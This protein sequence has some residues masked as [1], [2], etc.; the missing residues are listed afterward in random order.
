MCLYDDYIGNQNYQYYN[1]MHVNPME[2][3]DTSKS[4]YQFIQEYFQAG[5]KLHVFTLN[6]NK[7]VQRAGKHQHTVALYFLGCKLYQLIDSPLKQFFVENLKDSRWYDFKYTWFLACLYHDTASAIEKTAYSNE[8]LDFFLGTNNIK[9]N[10]FNHKP[11]LPYAD[12]F[13]FPEELV[14]NYFHYRIDYCKS[15]DHGILGGFLLF[16]RLR[17]NYDN[18]WRKCCLQNANKRIVDDQF[19][20]T[21]EK[22]EFEDRNWQIDHLDHFAIIADSVIAHNIWFNNNVELYKH[23]GLEPLIISNK[24]QIALTDRPLLFFLSLLDTIEPIKCLGRKNFSLNPVDA[25]KSVSIKLDGPDK[26]VI[27]V[28]KNDIN[29]R[30][31]F[32]EIEK[33]KN[34]LR[35]GVNCTNATTCIIKIK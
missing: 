22:F 8:P 1:N 10:V 15:V 3:F 25:L 30:L 7:E 27:T 32:E 17:E 4:S 9:H 31:W 20:Y 24:N 11:M 28:L 29:C 2:N 33:M 19:N 21:Y 5:R 14:E 12:L 6:F 35:V 13:T 23:Y 26:I 16:D 34:W 18:A